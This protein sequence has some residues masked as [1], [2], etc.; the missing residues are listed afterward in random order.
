MKALNARWKI[1]SATS[2]NLFR[3]FDNKAV[4][5]VKECFMKNSQLKIMFLNY[6]MYI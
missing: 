1:S 6:Y 3:F 4:T 2:K 5:D